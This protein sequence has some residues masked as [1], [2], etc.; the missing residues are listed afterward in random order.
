MQSLS[1]GYSQ[2]L[3]QNII[4]ALPSIMH[5]LSA[6]PNFTAQLSNDPTFATFISVPLD[7]S[8][9]ANS[10]AFIRS[11]GVSDVTIKPTRGLFS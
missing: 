10:F 1:L 3:S 6:F 5:Y 8:S 7:S 2:T 4:Y 11:P 9:Y